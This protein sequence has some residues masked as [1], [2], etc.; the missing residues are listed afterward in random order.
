[1]L[2]FQNMI[3]FF[4]K[5]SNRESSV[6]KV[7]HY[8]AYAFSAYMDANLFH[9]FATDTLGQTFL[10]GWGIVWTSLKLVIL[11]RYLI[12]RSERKS[13][14]K[15]NRKGMSRGILLL[16]GYLLFAGVSYWATLGFVQLNILGQ[17]K[18]SEVQTENTNI[19]S[20]DV[21]S[22]NTK[23][24]QGNKEI[25]GWQAEKDARVKQYA[26]NGAY[27]AVRDA[28]FIKVQSETDTKIALKQKEIEGWQNELNS[29]S[30]QKVEVSKQETVAL[31]TM[32]DALASTIPFNLV[33]TTEGKKEYQITGL[34]VQFIL[35][36]LISLAV[37]VALWVTTAV[38]RRRETKIRE[39]RMNFYIY[40]NSLFNVRGANLTPD[41]IISERTGI[42]MLDCKR[43]RDIL[44][45]N[46][47]D[48]VPLIR[49]VQGASSANFS[50]EAVLNAVERLDILE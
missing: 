32:F 8:S 22:L 43:Y 26:Q 6:S 48:G 3:K 36:N 24:K 49:S 47:Q 17:T 31:T 46:T 28:A 16:T 50:R 33:I 10:G 14:E 11:R 19:V 9:L 13:L 1:M 29:K 37:E 21:E 18:T 40:V 39:S 41:R 27:N 5:E 23:I 12:A 2:W 45:N 4:T 35:G 20:N 30:T 34:N 44:L 42:S 38:P 25:E 15:V 7:V